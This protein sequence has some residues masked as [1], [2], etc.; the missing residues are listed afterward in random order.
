MGPEESNEEGWSGALPGPPGGVI[1]DHPP[2]GF[3]AANLLGALHAAL[4][5]RRVVLHK[6][7][8][9]FCNAP[10][11]FVIKEEVFI[12]KKVFTDPLA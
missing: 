11:H 3:I 9:L 10:S 7:A 5:K 4:Y 12:H 6:T 8:R 1:A 2:G